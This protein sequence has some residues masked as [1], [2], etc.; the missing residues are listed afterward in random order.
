MQYCFN[1]GFSFV[2]S[3]W[4]QFL[5]SSVSLSRILCP[6]NSCIW[7][8]SLPISNRYTCH[9]YHKVSQCTLP[10][11]YLIPNI[12]WWIAVLV[13]VVSWVTETHL[14]V[15]GC[16]ASS[17]TSTQQTPASISSAVKRCQERE[18]LGSLWVVVLPVKV[19][20]IWV[21]WLLYRCTIMMDL[22]N[23]SVQ[24]T[25]VSPLLP[26]SWALLSYCSFQCSY[27]SLVSELSRY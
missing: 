18:S 6:C 1:S 13:S 25:L 19:Y 16:W 8:H 24:L 3:I 5:S 21:I 14:K 12:F 26:S 22:F 2:S 27:L 4:L 20:K 23:V 15:S 11:H 7:T 10:R 9:L 17:H